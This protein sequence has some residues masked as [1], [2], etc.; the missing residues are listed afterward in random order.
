MGREQIIV[1]LS[2]GPGQL[3]KATGAGAEDGRYDDRSAWQQELRQNH[4]SL[5]L[6]KSGGWVVDEV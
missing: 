4:T 3:T 5:T 2:S 6:E 1:V